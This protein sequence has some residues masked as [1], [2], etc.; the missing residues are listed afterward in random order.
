MERETAGCHV[1]V[2][3]PFW[4]QTF[5]PHGGIVLCSMTNFSSLIAPVWCAILYLIRMPRSFK[6]IVWSTTQVT[7][8]KRCFMLWHQKVIIH[9]LSSPPLHI[10]LAL[11]PVQSS[12]LC[13]VLRLNFW[14]IVQFHH[15]GFTNLL[16]AINVLFSNLRITFRIFCLQKHIFGM[17]FF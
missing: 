2:V 10:S 3:A 12:T 16:T 13:A 15:L 5:N 8:H 7:Q 4:I 14:T 6:E 1:V 17:F 11:T 9:W